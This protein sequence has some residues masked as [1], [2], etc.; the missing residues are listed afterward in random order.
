MSAEAGRLPF[1]RP[2][3]LIVDHGTAWRRMG[4]YLAGRSLTILEA[5]CGRKWP[6]EKGGHTITGIDVDAYALEHRT[7]VERDLDRAIVADLRD[8]ELPQETYDV[9]YCAFVLEHVDGARPVLDKF[10]HALK[11]GGLLMLTFPDRDS[12]YGFFSRYTPLW[13]HVLFR[14]YV[15]NQRD[16]GRP[17]FPPYATCYDPVIARRGFL[18][19]VRERGLTVREEYGFMGLPAGLE[20]C[21]KAAGALSL[22]RLATRHANLMY[23]LQKPGAWSALKARS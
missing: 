8:V 6:F 11:P 15:R 1:T 14:R 13:L 21:I 16:A 7:S 9:I 12:V 20:A 22:G 4:R 5:G 17:G 10:V 3:L 18:A 2:E 23:I 19:Y